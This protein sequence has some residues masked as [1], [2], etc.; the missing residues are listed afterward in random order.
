MESTGVDSSKSHEGDNTS[1][2]Q[3]AGTTAEEAQ[4]KQDRK[5][6]DNYDFLKQVGEGAFGY[7][8]LAVEKATQQLC[9]VKVLEKAHI[10]KFDKTKAVYR[11]KDILMKFSSNPNVIKID[12]VFQVGDTRH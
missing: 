8:Y 3:D 2:N 12:C 7:V 5:H 1:A 4:A 11:E 6:I 10:I 9:A